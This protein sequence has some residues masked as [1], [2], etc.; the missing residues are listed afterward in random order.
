MSRIAAMIRSAQADLVAETAK[1][2]AKA[3]RE[4][5]VI[6]RDYTCQQIPTLLRRLARFHDERGRIKM[7]LGQVTDRLNFALTSD[8][9]VTQ[10]I[11]AQDN[12]IAAMRRYQSLIEAG[13]VQRK[14]KLRAC[15]R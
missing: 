8:T 13:R 7:R 14:L 2:A 12:L 5:P 15:R 11:K 10:Y 6:A 1:E 9:D 4:D 3:S